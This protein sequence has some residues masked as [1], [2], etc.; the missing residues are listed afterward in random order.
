VVNFED[1]DGTYLA[2]KRLLA[3]EPLRRQLVENGRSD[4]AKMFSIETMI[5]RLQEI[6]AE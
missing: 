2:V 1:A 5:E 3:D 4:V 6:Y